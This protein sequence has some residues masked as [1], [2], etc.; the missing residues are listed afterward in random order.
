MN[1]TVK[2][3]A[4]DTLIDPVEAGSVTQ[5]GTDFIQNRLGSVPGR[6]LQDLVNSSP[7]GCMRA[8]PCC[9]PAARSTR[10]NSWSMEFR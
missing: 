8:M 2:V 3:S 9:I 4:S 10:R 7:A 1:E 5:I 6:D